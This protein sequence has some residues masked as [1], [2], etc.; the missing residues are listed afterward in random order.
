MQDYFDTVAATWDDDPARVK[1]SR[2]VADAIRAAVPLDDRPVTAELGAGTGLL[3]RSLAS[4]LGP[5]TLLDASPEMVAAASRA[6]AGLEG[7][8]AVAVDLADAPLS[9]GP[10]SLVISQLALHHIADVAGV[11]V[12]VF[13]ATAPG[14]RVALADLDDDPDGAFHS[15]HEH[16]DGHN[17][18]SREHFGRW[19]REAGFADVTFHDAGRL[20]KDVDGAEREFGIF[21]AVARR[22]LA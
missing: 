14:G 18:F 16:F 13:E 10:Y 1:R 5:T 11:L 21:L 8:S 19:L 22:P 12:R 2:R 17:G 9:G 15:N 6:V 20:K 3:A 4:E 7:W